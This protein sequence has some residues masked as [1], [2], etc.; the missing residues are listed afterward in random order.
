MCKCLNLIKVI[1]KFVLVASFLMLMSMDLNAV[2]TNNIKAKVFSSSVAQ[3]AGTNSE[4]VS[5]GYMVQL[6]VGL[7]IVLFCIVI[8][9]W[10]AKR[11]NRFHSTS[12]DSLQILGGMSM[13]ARERIVL[14]QVGSSQLL[15]G[16]SPGQI[17]TLHV[18]DEPVKVATDTASQLPGNGFSEK[19]TA[20]LSRNLKK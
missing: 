8:L 16:V 14:L 11:F 20:A 2:E 1:Y 3:S 13:G 15:L 12:D 6:V 18:L 4:P 10:V 9:A 7:V 5:A 19:L 17:N